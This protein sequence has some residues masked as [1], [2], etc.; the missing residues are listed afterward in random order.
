MG[1]WQFKK[2]NMKLPLKRQ[3]NI[4][5]P[6]AKLGPKIYTNYIKLFQ[7]LIMIVARYN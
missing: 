1:A 7:Y 5:C 4:T 2:G 3:I 6:Y